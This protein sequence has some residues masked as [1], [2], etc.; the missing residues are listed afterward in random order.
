[1]KK[2]LFV[3]TTLKRCGPVNILFDVVKYLNPEKFTAHV[4]T[5]CDEG[6]DSRREEFLALGVTTSSI[7]SGRGLSSILT[8]FKFK[9]F[10]DEI[11]PDVI[12]SIGFRAD[13]MGALCGG[14]IKKISSQLNYPFDDYVMTYGSPIGLAMSYLTV[15]ALKRYDSVVA[16]AEDVA[17]KMSA[18]RISCKVVNNAIDDGLFI[19]AVNDERQMQR[20][21]LKI[22]SDVGL[23]FI[24]IGVLTYRKQPLVALAAFLR[25]LERHPNAFLL[26][27]GDG[28]DLNVCRNFTSS[29]RRVAYFGQ[30]S[31]TRPYLVASDVYI[32]TSKAEGMPVSVLEALAVGLPV[33]LSDINPHREILSIDHQ[34]GVLAQ[35]GSVD[36]TALAML[37]VANSDLVRMVSHSR[38]IIETSLNS[39]VMSKRFQQI[40]AELS[41]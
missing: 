8:V 5:L 17:T 31:E 27:L 2:I 25:F 7:G 12:H 13:L 28:P 32:A 15:L 3:I 18:H 29:T 34:A 35:A 16:C 26:V 20:D 11:K 14:K 10:L 36:E 37:K 4:I 1:M 22:P 9:Q 21:R 41:L 23:V 6:G 30:V 39:R 40:Y 19:P 33:V 38:R 24:F